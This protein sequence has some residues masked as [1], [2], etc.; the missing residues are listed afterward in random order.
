M[1]GSFSLFSN[2]ERETSALNLLEIAVL[3]AE[4]ASLVKP[5]KWLIDGN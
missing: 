5:F 1:I 4:V 2:H 3:T